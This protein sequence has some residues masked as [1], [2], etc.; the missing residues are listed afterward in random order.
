MLDRD[1]SSSLRSHHRRPLMHRWGKAPQRHPDLRLKVLW[2]PKSFRRRCGFAEF[3][4]P[5]KSRRKKRRLDGDL[6][7][8]LD[9]EDSILLRNRRTQVLHGAFL[10]ALSLLVSPDCVLLME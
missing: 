4:E 3:A 6:Q 1:R 2:D 5:R 10:E 7:P 9:D 8:L